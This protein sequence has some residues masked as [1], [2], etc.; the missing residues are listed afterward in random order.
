MDTDFV[1]EKDKLLL[2]FVL[3]LPSSVGS[4][5]IKLTRLVKNILLPLGFLHVL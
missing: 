1:P 3:R 2:Q 5:L 4:E